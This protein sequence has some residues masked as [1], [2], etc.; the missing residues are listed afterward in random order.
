MKFLAHDS[1][2]YGYLSL[3]GAALPPEHIATRCGIPLEQYAT[4]LAELDAFGVPSRTPEKVIF[5]AELVQ[6]A[7][8]RKASKERVKRHRKCNGDVTPPVTLIY[9]GEDESERVPVVNPKMKKAYERELAYH[10]DARSV[11]F[12]LREAT[13]RLFHENDANLAIITARLRE[14]DGSF[15]DF[16]LMVDRQC[17]RWKGTDQEEY[18]RPETLFGKRKFD[19]YYAARK[20]PIHANNG[21][22]NGQRVDRNV[23][24]CNEGNHTKYGNLGKVVTPP[25]TQ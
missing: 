1:D 4:L 6:L 7:K 2:R 14:S 23:G 5:C 10:K 25:N 19:G 20:L 22:A 15:D 8:D 17:Q 24:T 16:K 12:Y 21:T 11:L 18:L 13:G 3:N 9:E